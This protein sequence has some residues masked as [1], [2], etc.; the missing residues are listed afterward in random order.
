MTAQNFS[1]I[2]C[3]GPCDFK[4][5]CITTVKCFTKRTLLRDDVT[6]DIHRG[7]FTENSG[8]AELFCRTKH[9]RVNITCCS[10]H[11]CNYDGEALNSA[12][13]SEESH[14]MALWSAFPYFLT[15]FLALVGIYILFSV[16]MTRYRKYCRRDEES[17]RHIQNSE[18]Q[19]VAVNLLTHREENDLR[20]H[21]AGASTIGE[22]LNGDI[23]SGSGSGLP[24]LVSRSIAK[25]IHLIKSIYKGRL[26]EVFCAK[27]QS[28]YVAVKQYSTL[29]E[30][31]WRRETEI[32]GKY[33]LSHENILRFIAP[34]QLD[35]GSNTRLWLI[36]D[37][38]A[39]RSLYD[40]L[41]E[42][43]IDIDQMLTM[44]HSI[45]NGLAHL[46]V[47]IE[48]TQGKPG[49]AHC[50]IKSTN[51]LLK[52]S[53]SCVISDLGLAVTYDGARKDLNV[54]LSGRTASPRYAAPEIL[55]G[56]LNR[57]D[58]E[59]FRRA[60]IYS[61]SL[62]LWEIVR[63]CTVD[64]RHEEYIL[65]YQDVLENQENLDEVDMMK[66]VCNQGRRPIIPERWQELDVLNDISQVIKECWK[67]NPAARLTMLRVKRRIEQLKSS[68]EM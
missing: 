39:E 29:Q 17:S 6:L 40:F 9:A 32:Y 54:P 36:T 67:P 57:K 1:C 43:T 22:A 16:A 68:E 50:N 4:R 8:P 15:A 66:I 47:E 38:H 11:L 63:R 37:Y 31:L 25:D 19:D 49:I 59:S 53:G 18:M 64:G 45:A 26:S 65:P 35:D 27:Y 24:H 60:D 42:N 12:L 41:S 20:A 28:E 33:N 56:S 3:E 52:R 51:V 13:E 55:D 34:D 10:E 46:H 7:C 44:A 48:G 58:F 23:T 21:P 14:V 30:D 5:T 61:F 62:V 2:E